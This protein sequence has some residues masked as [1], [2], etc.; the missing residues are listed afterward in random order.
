M[1]C[2]TCACL[3]KRGNKCR[4]Y[5]ELLENCPT[6]TKDPNYLKSIE[7]LTEH[8]K[9]YLKIKEEI[10]RTRKKRARMGTNS[11]TDRKGEVNC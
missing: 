7:N 1:K 2:E 5:T 3:D 10:K 6:Y 8:Y 11:I 4:V 9:G